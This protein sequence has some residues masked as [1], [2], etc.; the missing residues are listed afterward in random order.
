MDKDLLPAYAGIANAAA[1]LRLARVSPR[2][3]YQAI[4]KEGNPR[5]DTL[6]KLL[7]G[8]SLETKSGTK[9]G[10]KRA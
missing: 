7:H 3:Y 1:A 2:T 5:L 10:V 6:V 4:S 8:I 9:F